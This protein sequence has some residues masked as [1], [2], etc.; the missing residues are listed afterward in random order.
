MTGSAL[1]PPPP[2]TRIQAWP[3]R[4]SL[5]ADRAKAMGELHRASIG[6]WRLAQL[7]LLVSGFTVGWVSVG[8]AL[9]VFY[10]AIDVFS[11]LFGGVLLLLGTAFIVPT[12]LLI[13]FG[14]VRDGKVRARLR[15]WSALDSDPARDARFTS[16]GLSLTWFVP[17]FLMCA[18]G[19]W[20]CFAVPAGAEPGE[21]TV[22]E[23][24]LLMGLGMIL[25]LT[26]L[27]GVA[28]AVGHY[29]W[30]LRLVPRRAAAGTHV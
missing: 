13:G 17:S 6:V 27:I 10:E 12:G 7:W 14:L 8:A 21:N 24:V 5:L 20:T 25:W 9:R 30:A 19:L 11:H 1:P 4:E 2:P 22:P 26:G 29:R 16:P 18:G 23:V 15:E 28:K 3:D